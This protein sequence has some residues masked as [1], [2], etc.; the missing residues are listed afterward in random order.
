MFTFFNLLIIMRKLNYCVSLGRKSW[1]SNPHCDQHSTACFGGLRF[2]AGDIPGV[3]VP[4]ASR[5]CL[6]PTAVR[7]LWFC[8]WDPLTTLTLSIR[9]LPAS[10]PVTSNL[11]I[12]L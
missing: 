2:K 11:G 5:Q 12:F 9:K 8:G 1:P 4:E 3:E 6:H 7:D 10:L